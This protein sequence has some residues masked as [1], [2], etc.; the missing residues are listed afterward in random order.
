MVGKR[1]E[2]KGCLSTRTSIQEQLWM[3]QIIWFRFWCKHAGTFSCRLILLP[4]DSPKRVFI[5]CVAGRTVLIILPVDQGHTLSWSYYVLP[6]HI[7]YWSHNFL[8][9]QYYV[10]PSH[11]ISWSHFFLATLSKSRN[12]LATLFPGGISLYVRWGNC[13]NK[14]I[15]LRNIMELILCSYLNMAHIHTYSHDDDDDDVGLPA[16]SHQ[17]YSHLVGICH[18][19]EGWE[20]DTVTFPPCINQ[21]SIQRWSFWGKVIDDRPKVT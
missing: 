8:A 16:Y 13:A 19:D 4:S 18:N 2:E 12:F 20:Y 5:S 9:T 7:I 14:N 1:K 17:S 21:S 11:N 6:S 15:A 3:H 10:L